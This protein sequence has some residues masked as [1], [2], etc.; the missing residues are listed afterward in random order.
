MNSEESVYRSL[1]DQANDAI[2]IHDE[3]GTILAANMTASERLDY[4]LH[5][6][7][8][9]KISEIDKSQHARPNPNLLA[10]IRERGP[11]VFETIH[12]TKTGE[13]IPVEV[14]SKLVEYRGKEAIFS[15]AR[16]ISN[17]IA[18]REN[19]RRN[20]ATLSE[21]QRI[22]SV[23]SW[24]WRISEQTHEWSDEVFRLFGFMPQ[25]MQVGPET[26]FQY[27]HPDDASYV[28]ERTQ[29]TL[30]TGDPYDITFRIRTRNGIE[31]VV[32]ELG[33]VEFDEEGNPK[34]FFGTI[35]DI[36]AA[37]R[38]AQALERSHTDLQL[39]TSLLQH[40]LR[41]DLQIIMTQSE[42]LS[43][44]SD[45]DPE[46]DKAS[47][48][49]Q[50]ASVRMKKV[51]DVFT[52][53]SE[54]QDDNLISMLENAIEQ[55]ESTNPDVS[56]DME[57]NTAKSRIDIRAGRLLPL[58]WANLLRNAVDYAGKQAE[59]RI[60]VEQGRELVQVDFC[61]NGPG[62]SRDVLPNLFEKGASTSG[63]GFGLYLS[64]KVLQAYGGSIGLLR[65]RPDEGTCFRVT[66]I[67]A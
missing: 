14:S 10:M 28:R 64:R 33:E 17:R 50:S 48:V 63:R 62:I 21:A 16:D 51:L 53:P 19:L 1:F 27:V 29:K 2:F 41:S 13:E 40:D 32:H 65:T 35:R 44:I 7:L 55:I 18:A 23:G 4:S 58:V 61:D 46:M 34:R 42:A 6:L 36:T 26:F 31:K 49:I 5:E 60:R 52:L 24:D 8:Q 57:T 9:M 20:Q 59:I 11:L 56:I 3:I 47:D 25:E 67:R 43:F 30:K 15:T 22:A 54:T 45:L 38:A 12:M 37:H 66:L 39:Y